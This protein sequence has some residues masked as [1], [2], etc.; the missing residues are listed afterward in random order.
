MLKSIEN[1]QRVPPRL[2]LLTTK[3]LKAEKGIAYHRAHIFRMVKEGKF[4]RPIKLGL[5]RG[6][7]V[8]WVEHEIDQWLLDRMAER[9]AA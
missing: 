5:G 7:A 2:R 1:E 8:A 3:D 9:D 6:G 4:P